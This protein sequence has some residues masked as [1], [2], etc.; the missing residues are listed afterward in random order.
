MLDSPPADSAKSDDANFDLFRYHLVSFLKLIK[1]PLPYPGGVVK[2]D[3]MALARIR[4]LCLPGTSAGS[5]QLARVMRKERMV[6]RE[7]VPFYS[8]KYRKHT[9]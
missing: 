9:P 1:K 6:I 7:I 2:I 4:Q 5:I 3:V 8:D